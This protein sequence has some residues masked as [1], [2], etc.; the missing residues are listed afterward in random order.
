MH[1]LGKDSLR[2]VANFQYKGSDTSPVYKYFLS[3]FA[4]LCV[5]KFTPLWIAPNL[6][7]FIG[8][9]ST[10]L[11]T[12]CVLIFN[13]SLGPNGP[14][15]LSLVTGIGIFFYQTL[16]NMDGKQARRTGTSSAL[17]MLFD[18]GCDAINAGL[19]AIPVGSALGTGWTVNLFFS[20]W[21]GFVPFYFQTWEEYYLGEMNLPPIN[22]PSEGLLIAVGMCFCS[23]FNGSQFWHEVSYSSR[24]KLLPMF[25]QVVCYRLS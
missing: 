17:G 8:L 21:C 7:T 14:H 16:D 5:D 11:S 6:I 3:P 19:S 24:F 22:G 10:V 15:W 12:V 23:F 2:K 18:H 25:I 20:L 13:P 4:Q 9:M 1:L